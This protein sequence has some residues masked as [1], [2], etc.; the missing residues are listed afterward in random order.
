MRTVIVSNIMS[1]DGYHEGPGGNVMALNMDAAFDAYNLERFRSAGTVLLGGNSFGMFSSYWPGIADAPADPDNPALDEVNREI[2]RV[3][4]ALP[5]A[6]VSD[7]CVLSADNPW[8]DSTT[9][10]K[11]GEVA[12]WLRA[13]RRRGSGDIVTFGSRTMWN[14]LLA[15]GLVDELHLMVG[16]KAL[17]GGTP[18]FAAPA[19]LRLL[20]TRRFDGSDNVVLLYAPVSRRD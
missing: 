13:E 19:E 4:N 16:P 17:G 7:S 14:G 1:V 12:D 8:Y 11:R 6:V 5:K 15:K 20:E 18:I 3:F 2:S 9:V 10:V